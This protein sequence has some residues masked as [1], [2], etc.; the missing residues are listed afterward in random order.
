VFE[1][2]LVLSLRAPERGGKKKRS[3]ANIGTNSST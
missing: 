2:T 3:A 1:V